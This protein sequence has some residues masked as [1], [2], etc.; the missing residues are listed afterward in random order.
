MKKS[1][2]AVLCLLCLLGTA[3]CDTREKSSGPATQKIQN[4][5][6]AAVKENTFVSVS[7]DEGLT[8]MKHDSGFVLLD[9]RRSDEFAA[10]HIP[11]AILHTNELMTAENTESLL[12][13]KELHVYVYCRSGR[14]SKEASQKLVSYG[15]TAVTE[16][17][18]ILDY[19]GPVE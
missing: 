13:D 18:G 1:V 14:R 2:I 9:V 16:I 6:E 17:G 11:G 8:L 12:P 4:L 15:Y 10:G 19:T 7:M 3:G 5:Q